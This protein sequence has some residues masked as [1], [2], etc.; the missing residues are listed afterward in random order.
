[1]EVAWRVCFSTLLT[2]HVTGKSVSQVTT[3]LWVRLIF[4]VYKITTARQKEIRTVLYF[5]EKTEI[6]GGSCHSQKGIGL[7]D[8]RA[9]LTHRLGINRGLLGGKISL[10]SVDRLP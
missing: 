10:D 9:A 4:Q 8:D 7:Y 5:G 3:N 2:T 6:D 1:M